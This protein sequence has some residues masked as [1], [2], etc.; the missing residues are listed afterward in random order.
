MPTPDASH[1]ELDDAS[2]EALLDGLDLQPGD[3][4]LPPGEPYPFEKPAKVASR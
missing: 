2:L 1:L 3:T 4:S